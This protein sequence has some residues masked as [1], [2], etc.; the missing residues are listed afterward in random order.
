MEHSWDFDR[1]S[2]S[3]RRPRVRSILKTS[4]V[5]SLH[6]T[7][8]TISLPFPQLLFLPFSLPLPLPA[9]AF[10]AWP[11][12]R[13]RPDADAPVPKLQLLAAA[14]A[15]AGRPRALGRRRALGPLD[16]E[17]RED[18]QVVPFSSVRRGRSFPFKRSGTDLMKLKYLRWSYKNAKEVFS[19]R[20]C[21]FFGFWGFVYCFHDRVEGCFHDMIFDFSLFSPLACST[22]GRQVTPH[23]PEHHTLLVKPVKRCLL[24]P[25]FVSSVPLKGLMEVPVYKSG[26]KRISE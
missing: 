21:C 3:S 18:R 10:G 5:L 2:I 9:Q 24:R 19:T 7:F 11:R 13:L 4:I 25:G 20:F 23:P 15:S 14:H 12:P 6:L 16:R 1:C 26:Q 8:Q 22:Q 17:D